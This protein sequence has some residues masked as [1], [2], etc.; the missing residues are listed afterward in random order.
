MQAATNTREAKII[1]ARGD[2]V[3]L[4][5]DSLRL[6]LPQHD[7]N[8]S[9]YLEQAP[10]PTDNPGLFSFAEVTGKPQLVA[11]LS[12]QM[13][14]MTT[15]PSGR[16]LLTRLSGNPELLLAWTEMRVMIDAAL[17]FHPIPQIVR[18]GGALI[19]AYVEMDDGELAFCTTADRV[20]AEA[21]ISELPVAS[22]AGVPN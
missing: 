4:R 13:Q 3:M 21:Q 5:A 19:D 17:E 11:A 9:E 16:F 6:L 10:T 20:L 15:F 8:V 22:E 2:F 1:Q 7:V 12:D 18:G 14:M